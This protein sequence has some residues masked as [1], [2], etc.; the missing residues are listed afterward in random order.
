MKKEKKRLELNAH[1]PARGATRS[2]LILGRSLHYLLRVQ[3]VSFFEDSM[4]RLY[5][6]PIMSNDDLYRFIKMLLYT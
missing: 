3:M 5:Y 1:E 4:R 6:L 2:R